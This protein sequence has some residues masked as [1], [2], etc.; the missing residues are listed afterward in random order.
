VV[1]IENGSISKIQ[2]NQAKYNLVN[3]ENHIVL[4]S[5]SKIMEVD[6]VE[7]QTIYIEPV[8]LSQILS[9]S[10]GVYVDVIVMVISIGELEIISSTH[11]TELQKKTIKIVDDSKVIFDCVFWNDQVFIHLF[12]YRSR[13]NKVTSNGLM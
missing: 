3:N 12:Y 9:L 2:P 13:T 4:K 11:S 5:I 7:I 10:D 6:D 1:S 8:A